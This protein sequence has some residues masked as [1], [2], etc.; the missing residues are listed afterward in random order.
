M[1]VTAT[2]KIM[3]KLTKVL[4]IRHFPQF[5]NSKVTAN[6]S[7]VSLDQ[8]PL[9]VPRL[10]RGGDTQQ[11]VWWEACSPGHA[12]ALNLIPMFIDS[13]V[14]SWLD[15]T[16]LSYRQQYTEM[17]I[18]LLSRPDPQWLCYI[19]LNLPSR[20]GPQRS[21]EHLISKP[22]KFLTLR[23]V[24]VPFLSNFSGCN[25]IHSALDKDAL[26]VMCIY[27]LVLHSIH[28]CMQLSN[29]VYLPHDVQRLRDFV[30]HVIIVLLHIILLF[31]H[32][33]TAQ[34]ELSVSNDA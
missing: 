17:S 16:L 31:C 25:V 15:C 21:S 28:F 13:A 2:K 1:R 33:L 34:T 18:L 3:N 6:S 27:R 24:C 14:A 8:N 19:V 4:K 30:K 12:G 26:L 20:S 9:P 10:C 5:C 32:S 7:K 23:E 29:I 11:H 22:V